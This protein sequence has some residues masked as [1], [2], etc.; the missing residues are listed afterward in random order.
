MFISVAADAKYVILNDE[1]IS[2]KV[3]SKIESLGSELFLKTGIGVYVALPASLD[4]KQ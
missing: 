3:T 4:K 2:N 1:I